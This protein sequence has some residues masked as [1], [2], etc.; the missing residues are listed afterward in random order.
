MNEQINEYLL[1]Y[2]ETLDKGITNGADFL[3]GEIPLYIQEL[4][5]W[6][7]VKTGIFT[8]FGAVL[9]VIGVFFIIKY[10][11]AKKDSEGYHVITLTHDDRGDISPHILVTT[12][13][14]VFY[15]LVAFSMMSLDWL[16]IIVAPRVWLLE[17][18]SSL[19]K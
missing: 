4:L 18:A 11:G 6:Y 13:V 16:Q 8:L 15:Y 19:V 3:V 12:V 14:A 1:K 2:L 5:M 10:S 9:L 17:Y 7:A